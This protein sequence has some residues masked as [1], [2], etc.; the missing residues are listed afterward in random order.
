[1]PPG[2]SDALQP[3]CRCNVDAIAEDIVVVEMM[4]PDGMDAMRN[5]IRLPGISVFRQPCALELR[6]RIALITGTGKFYQEYRRRWVLTMR[7]AMLA[8]VGLEQAFSENYFSCASVPP[9]HLEPI[10]SV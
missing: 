6:R 9:R 7:H 3:R 1:M 8:I 4:S 5:S 10:K 2:Q